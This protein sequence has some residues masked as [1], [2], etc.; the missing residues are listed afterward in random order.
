MTV[1]DIPAYDPSAETT[2]LWR[3]LM[4]AIEGVLR[5]GRF[6]AGPN[7]AAFEREMADYL[8]TA[9]AVSVNSGTD[10]L[11]IGLR[12]MA[13]GAGDE[14]ITSPFSF[15]ATA[16]AISAVG[17]TPVFADIDPATSTLDPDDVEARIT[18]R[19][20]AVIPVHLF[21]HAAD[22]DR[23]V[24][25]ARRYGLHVLEDVAQ[26]AG[27]ELHGRKLG[28]IG[29]AG[30]FS[31]FPTKNLGGFGDGGLLATDDGDLAAL[32]RMLRTHGS[33]V[34]YQN[35]LV[36]YNSRLDEVQAAVLRVK[37]PRLDE[38][39]RARRVAAARYHDRL[40]DAPDLVLPSETPGAVHVYHQYTVRIRGERRDEIRRHLHEDGIATM[41]YYPV[42]IH[43]LPVYRD[44][45]CGPLPQAELAAREVLSLPMWP[46]I[47]VRVQGMVISCLA[48]RLGSA[49]E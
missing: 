28:S 4:C 44:L 35:E 14:V 9:H 1:T 21:G 40:R 36:G 5:S 25:L 47:P 13:V 20:R 15:F 19:T 12:A 30:A 32:A 2:A 29:T 49:W 45:A 38:A 37:L 17:A 18:P 22:L 48:A 23:L 3:E 16:E 11:V 33:A 24:P 41:V 6:I 7:V 42:P 39:N 8:G 31:F 34:K 43:R 27:A 10:A 46:G 26:A